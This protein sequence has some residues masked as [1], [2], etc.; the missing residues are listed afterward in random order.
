MRIDQ[1]F[2]KGVTLAIA[3]IF[4]IAF[5]ILVYISG[6]VAYLFPSA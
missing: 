1:K 2:P 4:W 6:Q 3:I 5:I